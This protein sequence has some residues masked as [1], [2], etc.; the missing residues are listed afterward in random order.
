M[1]WTNK[2]KNYTII[3]MAIAFAASIIVGFY[4]LSES[5]IIGIIVTIVGIMNITLLKVII[6]M[7]TEMSDNMC[8]LVEIFE[9]VYE[10]SSDDC[11]DET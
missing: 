7:F 11:E 1:F 9:D 10:Y 8:K 2:V 6:M 4:F 3:I 5:I